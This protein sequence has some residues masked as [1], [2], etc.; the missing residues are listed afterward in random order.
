M[1][2]KRIVSN[3]AAPDPAEARAFYGDILGLEEAMNLGWIITYRGATTAPVQV[4]A[5]S[6]G[7]AGAPIPDLSVEVDDLEEALRRVRAA[8]I[9][10]EY[11]PVMEPWG[12]ERFFVR[13]PFG[14]LINIARHAD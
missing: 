12:I 2:V 1:I 8:G 4:S 10:I 7:G 3:I 14:K 13:D 6:E 5:A 11:G 9:A